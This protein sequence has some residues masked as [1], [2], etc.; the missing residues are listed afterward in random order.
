MNNQSTNHDIGI[1]HSIQPSLQQSL[2]RQRTRPDKK[3]NRDSTEC[4][5]SD[6]SCNAQQEEIDNDSFFD[7]FDRDEAD[8]WTTGGRVGTAH[9]RN[10]SY[11][12]KDWPGKVCKIFG[13]MKSLGGMGKTCGTQRWRREKEAEL[14]EWKE[15]RDKKKK[16]RQKKWEKFD[17]EEKER[18]K[19]RAAWQRQE[20]VREIEYEYRRAHLFDIRLIVPNIIEDIEEEEN[21]ED[22]TIESSKRDRGNM[23][24][25]RPNKRPRLEAHLDG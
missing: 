2:L 21:E 4:E 12:A 20:R 11:L 22:V 1:I 23:C 13:M 19:R 14:K 3:K 25:S 6:K 8:D 18:E 7:S 17:R 5:Y 15:K 24:A 16:E 9:G 10:G